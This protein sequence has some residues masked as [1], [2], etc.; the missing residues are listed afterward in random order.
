MYKIVVVTLPVALLL[1]FSMQPI[2]AN[3]QSCSSPGSGSTSDY[4]YDS[5]ANTYVI[6]TILSAQATLMALP[7]QTPDIY[8]CYGDQNSQSICL[9]MRQ[10]TPTPTVTPTPTTTP[11][12]T[13]REA[14]IATTATVIAGISGCVYDGPYATPTNNWRSCVIQDTHARADIHA[15]W[16]A[17]LVVFTLLIT[18]VLRFKS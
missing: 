10:W 3:A 12:L 6:C 5:A 9:T 14:M 7:T 2:V 11:T 13:T 4:A 18:A 15:D 8:G 17:P 16:W 1:L